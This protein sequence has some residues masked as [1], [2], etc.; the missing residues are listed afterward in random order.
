MQDIVAK[1]EHQ[2]IVAIGETG[3]DYYRKGYPEPD[4]QKQSLLSHIEAARITGLPLIIHNRASDN[5]VAQILYDEYMR[6]KNRPFTGVIHCFSASRELALTSLKIG[7]Y[8]SMSGIFTRK[9]KIDGDYLDDIVANDIPLDRLLVETDSP[10]LVPTNLQRNGVSVNEPSYVTYVA[11]K[12]AN[13]KG[14]SYAEISCVT[15]D[16]FFRLFSKAKNCFYK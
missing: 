8:I 5:D 16:N 1:C 4:L 2:K 3:L 14:V 7:F 15:T 12:L 13:I 9:I 11:E 10:Y 6:D